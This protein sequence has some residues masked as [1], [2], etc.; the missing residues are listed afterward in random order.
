M[1]KGEC[2]HC[3]EGKGQQDRR[4]K[5]KATDWFGPYETREQA[6]ARAERTKLRKVTACGHC[7]P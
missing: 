6:F 7:K 1:H 3:N 2:P 4:A 5:L